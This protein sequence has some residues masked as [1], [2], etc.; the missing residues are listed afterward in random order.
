MTRKMYCRICN[1][2]TTWAIKYLQR[3]S[4]T[5]ERWICKG[6]GHQSDN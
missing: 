2:V 1:K 6:C 5:V 4:L 3:G